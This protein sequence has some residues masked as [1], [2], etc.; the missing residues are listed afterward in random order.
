MDA[1]TAKLI[2]EN[3]AMTLRALSRLLYAGRKDDVHALGWS[4]TLAI[5]AKKTDAS[6]DRVR[7]AAPVNDIPDY[8]PS[9]AKG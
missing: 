2:L 7:D 9:M 5:Q 3:Q 6:I 1:A 8:L 4:D